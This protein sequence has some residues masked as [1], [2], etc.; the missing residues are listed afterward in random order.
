M[1]NSDITYHD[2]TY[3]NMN[4]KLYDTNEDNPLMDS[5]R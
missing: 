1:S 2:D 5:K 4:R 3:K